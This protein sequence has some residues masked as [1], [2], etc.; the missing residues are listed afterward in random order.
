MFQ[1]CYIFKASYIQNFKMS[2]FPGNVVSMEICCCRYSLLSS[3]NILLSHKKTTYNLNFSADGRWDQ[4]WHWYQERDPEEEVHP[5][6]E[7]AEEDGGLHLLWR[8]H[9][10]QLPGQVPTTSKNGLKA[11]SLTVSVNNKVNT[12]FKFISSRVGPE[13]RGYTYSLIQGRKSL[14]TIL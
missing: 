12:N 8:R 6:V 14:F 2:Y 5:G 11:R 4:G 9:N 10:C 1:N 7:G 3:L 13:Y